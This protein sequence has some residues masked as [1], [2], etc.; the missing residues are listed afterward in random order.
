MKNIYIF[1]ITDKDKRD[2]PFCQS[3][4]H[5]MQGILYVV[6][7]MEQNKYIYRIFKPLSASP[8]VKS[9]YVV[10]TS[11]DVAGFC[12]LMEIIYA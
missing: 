5:G 4:Y 12:L 9:A 11:D 3:L 6:C 1:N 10:R 2:I 8:S 7:M